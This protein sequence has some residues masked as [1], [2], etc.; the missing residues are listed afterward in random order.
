[1]LVSAYSEMS[2]LVPTGT[3]RND[4]SNEPAAKQSAPSG[5]ALNSAGIGKSIGVL[6]AGHSSMLGLAW[7]V[8]N[9]IAT[10]WF[11]PSVNANGRVE[12]FQSLIVLPDTEMT[13]SA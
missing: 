3:P 9:A 7:F 12:P 8:S 2:P 11:W 5:A 1:M 4:V 13:W 6:T 10:E